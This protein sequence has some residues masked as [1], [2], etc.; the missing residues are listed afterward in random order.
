M[1]AAAAKLSDVLGLARGASTPPISMVDRVQGGLAVSA[2]EDI[3]RRI[4]P[5]DAGFK[6]RIVAKATL[7]RRK[8]ARPARLSSEESERLVR[9]AGVWE[10]AQ[11][12]WG[13]E[14]GARR[15]L[16]E[17]H[18]LLDGRT[19]VEVTLASEL[20]GKLVDQVL[21]RLAYGSAV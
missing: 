1:P 18:P 6:H 21:G 9:L 4:A 16:F 5:E 12:V 8:E 14:A 11:E 10:L 15:F 19:P 7:A 13:G 17:P 2:L 20:G 3:A